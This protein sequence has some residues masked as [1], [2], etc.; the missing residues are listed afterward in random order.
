[1]R[2]I[3]IITTVCALLMSASSIGRFAALIAM[4]IAVALVCVTI[5][6]SLGFQHRLIYA[7][8]GVTAALSGVLLANVVF[9]LVPTTGKVIYLTT[10]QYNQLLITH[11]L[12]IGFFSLIAIVT[13]TTTG[14]A[15]PHLLK[16]ITTGPQSHTAIDSQ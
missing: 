8:V 6:H 16:L 9:P 5:A 3:L 15:V 7:A 10:Q 4:P 12:Q 1:M 2:L 11:L 14:L 13:G